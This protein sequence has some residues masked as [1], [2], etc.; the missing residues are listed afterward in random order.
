MQ[1]SPQVTDIPTLLSILSVFLGIISGTL[2]VIAIWLS[3]YFYRRGNELY[4]KTLDFQ[5]R[6]ETT[7][8]RIELLTAQ[9]EKA[10]MRV[11]GRLLDG[12]LGQLPSPTRMDE[13]EEAT[14]LQLAEKVGAVLG[15]QHAQ[16]A[17]AIQ[18]SIQEVV[19]NA[20]IA[21]KAQVGPT[22]MAYDWG[23]FVRRIDELERTHKFLGVALLHKQIFASESNM[24]EALQYALKNGILSQE[25]VPNLPGQDHPVRACKL[26]RLNEIVMKA[27]TS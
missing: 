17:E 26:N 7:V 27:L 11:T 20:F 13:T 25:F 19:S 5:S 1:V 14:V 3:L 23:P 18:K 16:E 24:R 4:L 8:G 9:M 15:P 2:A 22:S 21:V 10:S 12:V 6:T